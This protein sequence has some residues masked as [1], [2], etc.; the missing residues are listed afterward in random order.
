MSEAEL[1]IQWS[2]NNENGWSFIQ[3]W[4]SVTFGLIA[5]AHF[6]EKHLNLFV[7][8]LVIGL[9]CSFSFFAITSLAIFINHNADIVEE[10]KALMVSGNIS[11]SSAGF[12]RGFED[13]R[14]LNGIAA[15]ISMFGGFGGSISYLIYRYVQAVRTRRIGDSHSSPDV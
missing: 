11:A 6:F 12:L 14:V 15:R 7:V 10:L 1:L 2:S 4:A 9:Y 13:I 3:W 8:I 5:L